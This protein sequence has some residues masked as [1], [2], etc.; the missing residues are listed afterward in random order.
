MFPTHSKTSVLLQQGF[1]NG[2]SRFSQLEMRL[3]DLPT[4]EE[5]FR[6]FAVFAE[7]FLA[8]RTLPQVAEIW[9]EGS[10][11]PDARRRHALPERISG[12]DGIFRTLS[13]EIHPY[14]LFF[15]PGRPPLGRK[16][17]QAFLDLAERVPQPLLFS[18]CTQLPPPLRTQGGF[19][20]VLGN[21]LDR[22][23]SR[24]FNAMR[25]WWQG[26]GMVPDRLP[27]LSQ[28]ARYVAGVQQGLERE[29][30]L[31]GVA[32]PGI[33]VEWLTLKWA[34]GMGGGRIVLVVAPSLASLRDMLLIWRRHVVWS[35]LAALWVGSD[36][37]SGLDAAQVRQADWDLPLVGESEMVRRF[38]SWRF[39]GVRVVLTTYGSV[40]IVARAMVGFAPLDL[41]IFLES[42]ETLTDPFVLEDD[43][44]PL[45]KRLFLA[46]TTRHANVASRDPDGEPK[47]LWSMEENVLYG[48][49]LPV[50]PLHKAVGDG[51]LRPWQLL[52]PVVPQA[53]GGEEGWVQNGAH[54]I[55]LALLHRDARH[56]HAYHGTPQEA[57]AFTGAPLTALWEPLRQQGA[58]LPADLLALHLEGSASAA[59]REALLRRF[60]LADRAILNTVRCLTD[61]SLF[62]PAD[63]LFFSAAPKKGKWEVGRAMAAILSKTPGAPLAEGQGPVRGLLSVPL[64]MAAPVDAA[65][66]LAPVLARAVAAAESL[67][68]VVQLLRE[69]DESLEREIGQVGE[70]Y[71]RTGEWPERSGAGLAERFVFLLPASLPAEWGEGIWQQFLERLCSLWDRRFGQWQRPGQAQ[72]PVVVE[73]VEQQR[74][75]YR[76][77]L[78]RRERVGRLEGAGFV[79]DPKQAAWDAQFAALQRYRQVQGHAQVPP[80]W[81]DDPGLAEWVQ[82]QRR[83][84][85]KGRLEPDAVSR[86]ESVGFVWDPE[87]AA[88]DEQFAHFQAFQQQHGHGQVPEHWPAQP[89]LAEWA[90]QQRLLFAKGTL[91][92]HRFA[93]LSGLG[94]C[95]DLDQARWEEHFAAFLQFKQ[96]QE[97]GRIPDLW[98]ENP[99]L[100]LWAREQRKERERGKLPIERQV[101]LDELGFCWDLEVAYWE[102][103][104]EALMGFQAV[105]GHCL[106]PASWPENPQ[107]A[108]WV[109]RQ[110]REWRAGRL[111]EERRV[112]LDG[113]GFVWDPEEQFWQARYAELVA[114]HAAQ[115]HCHPPEGQAELAEWVRQQRRAAVNQSL[116]GP[117]RAALEALGFIWD[118]QEAEWDAMCFALQAFRTERNHCI[119]PTQLP[120]N[121]ALARWVGA[122]RRSYANG[123]L[124]PE[125]VQR[126]D[127]LG[128]IWDAKAILWEE[129]FA[130]LA[131]F[132]RQYD[133]CLVPESYPENNQLAWWVVAQRKAYKSG[134]L[135]PERVERL[136]GLGFFWDPLEV[137]WYEMFLS[138]AQYQEQ[139]G[140]CVITRGTGNARLAAWVATQRQARLHGHLSQVRIERL[141]S[142][143]F[144]WEQKEVVLEEML[145]ELAA[146]KEAHGHCNVPVPWPDYPAL[147]LWVQFQRQEYKKGRLD[148]NRVQRLEGLG[149]L[150]E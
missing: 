67:W 77:G 84:Y 21:D 87:Q 65:V 48:P 23:S 24:D 49:V 59:E 144:V 35:D 149:F 66:P 132:R 27:P 94:F 83:E 112:R 9:P 28:Q 53:T 91:A 78:L 119:V 8:I 44:L 82:Q 141:D 81:P 12:A 18:N 14:Q 42:Q 126:L 116:S 58:R 25:R 17:L 56:I 101:L 137:Q 110:R 29:D 133:N 34:E 129:M 38:F 127:G 80:N 106:V 22:L 33:G 68:E 52:I 120:E 73:W 136:N 90:K 86:L 60:A 121:P 79:W 123:L 50:A 63:L 51:V 64:P 131:E 95:W 36:L 47:R 57:R 107:L 97:H 15:R 1:F 147:G 135:E 43:N 138:L 104:M 45:R 145:T 111:L 76:K 96:T 103:Q 46:A 148:P 20:C 140:R 74:R 39:P 4:A 41:G 128:F 11:P 117:R 99:G 124:S 105:H 88:W 75:A 85:L 139:Y 118:P 6:A 142:L 37:P 134:Q 115:G 72:E 113:V 55:A 31:L 102:E 16:D 150:W 30:R 89:A 125:R 2:L 54:A 100:A 146:F 71:G 93:P 69:L 122:V 92:A 109:A 19:H 10:I 3:A 40:R 5:Q 143:G 32:A 98:P 130:A 13:G 62:P 26:G 7:A 61:G 70:Q 108:D 114:L